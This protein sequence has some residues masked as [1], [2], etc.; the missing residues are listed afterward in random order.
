MHI[1]RFVSSFAQKSSANFAQKVKRSVKFARP[2]RANTTFFVLVY[3]RHFLIFR[4]ANTRALGRSRV[5][6]SSD[7][8]LPSAYFKHIVSHRCCKAKNEAP[9]LQVN[10]QDTTNEPLGYVYDRTKQ[11]LIKQIT[12]IRP[13]KHMPENA[14]NFN[15][16]K[17]SLT[18]SNHL[19]NNS[20]NRKDEINSPR[21][22]SHS[23]RSPGAE[24]E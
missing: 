4:I 22:K 3:Q 6:M 17:K 16:S 10:S 24:D 23:H 12:F 9:S 5:A 8:L 7:N 20:N 15:Q 11:V 19:H 1:K 2:R 21:L 14:N 13:T 18:H